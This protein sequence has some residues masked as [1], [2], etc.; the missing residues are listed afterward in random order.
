MIESNKV[1]DELANRGTTVIM[2]PLQMISLEW[3]I[4]QIK[5][6]P[7]QEFSIKR[8]QEQKVI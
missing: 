3:K 4:K 8:I 5:R 6:I 2:K 1:A 7:Q